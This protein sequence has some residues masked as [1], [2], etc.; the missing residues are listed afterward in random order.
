MY[1]RIENILDA[2]E[3]LFGIVWREHYSVSRRLGIALGIIMI[4]IFY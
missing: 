3:F 2:K 4:N 1:I